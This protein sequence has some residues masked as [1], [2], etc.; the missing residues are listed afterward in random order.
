MYIALHQQVTSDVEVDRFRLF[1]C[2]VNVFPSR[3]REFFRMQQKMQTICDKVKSIGSNGA[4]TSASLDLR[5]ITVSFS[6]RA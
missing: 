1:Y 4:K 2:D 3:F 5:Q 6:S